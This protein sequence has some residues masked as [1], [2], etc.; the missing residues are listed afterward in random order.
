MLAPFYILD[1]LL[2]EFQ[3]I[4]FTTI[5]QKLFISFGITLVV[6][7]ISGVVSLMQLKNTNDELSEIVNDKNLKL[8]LAQDLATQVRIGVESILMTSALTDASEIKSISEKGMAAEKK[9]GDL[10]ER[11][12]QSYK[13]DPKGLKL[14][15]IFFDIGDKKSR[16]AFRRYIQLIQTGA[17][18]EANNWLVNSANPSLQLL[19][20]S[21]DDIVEYQVNEISEIRDSSEIKYITARTLS[22]SALF[23]SIICGITA[24]AIFSQSLYR[25]LGAE[26][27]ELGVTALKISEGNLSQLLTPKKDDSSSVF[28]SIVRMQDS[29]RHLV[30]D[31][32]ANADNVAISSEEISLGNHDLSYRTERQATSLQETS[33]TMERLGKIVNTTAENATLANKMAKEASEVATKGGDVVDMVVSKMRGISESS[34]RIEAI[35]GVIDG[36]AFQTNILAL[37]AA[38][39]A[40]RAGEQGRG[41]AVVAGEVRT[42]ARRSSDAAKEIAL[43]INHSVQQVD[44]GAEL[45][46]KAGQTMVEIVNSIENVNSILN[47]ILQSSHTQNVSVQQVGAAI[48]QIDK[49]TQQNAALVEESA[50]ASEN[51]KKQAHQLVDAVAEFELHENVDVLRLT[52]YRSG[53]M[54][55]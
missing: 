9:F 16:P 32:R 30:A 4:I 33:A 19:L 38:V 52:S 27:K 51:L 43:L 8:S 28:A 14:V 7:L 34:R 41:F 49:V 3:M 42:L 21:I 1:L 44:Q 20:Q 5:R 48:N 47:E 18:D 45:V 22:I 11:L 25:E 10:R 24:A 53:Y 15:D 39:E 6:S 37:N 17:R 54:R 13:N 46:D 35:I 26:P 55:M 40:A 2:K 50:A 31:V 36:I 12:R 23:L 29:L